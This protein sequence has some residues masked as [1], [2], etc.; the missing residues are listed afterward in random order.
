MSGF[1]LWLYS[2]HDSK[3]N[4]ITT[5]NMGSI[6]SPVHIKHGQYCISSLLHL[7][8]FGLWKGIGAPTHTVY[9]KKHAHLQLKEPG[10]LQLGM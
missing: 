4:I 9:P 3:S 8:V 10:P 6:R 5:C 2:I 1:T 7:Y